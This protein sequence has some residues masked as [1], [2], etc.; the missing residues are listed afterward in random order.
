[1]ALTHASSMET[2]VAQLVGELATQSAWLAIA[3][4]IDPSGQLIDMP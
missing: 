1:M 4:S 2:V 3:F